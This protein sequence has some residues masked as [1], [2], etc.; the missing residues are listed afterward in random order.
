MQQIDILMGFYYQ[1][2]NRNDYFLD[3]NGSPSKCG[4]FFNFIV[5]E[6]LDDDE[7]PVSEELGDDCL[8]KRCSYTSFDESFP[9]PHDLQPIITEQ[10]KEI[11][12]FYVLQHCYKYNQLP[13]TQY[14]QMQILNATVFNKNTK[15]NN[16]I[17]LCGHFI[18]L[19]HIMYTYNIY[20][21]NIISGD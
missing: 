17:N 16:K 19:Q 6:E 4:K 8:P 1:Q 13:S 9:F 21:S 14:I 10:N 11:A 12:I 15:C 3:D 2:L 20:L 5:A 7:L 18:R